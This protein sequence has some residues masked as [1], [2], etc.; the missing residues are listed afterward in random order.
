MFISP[1]SDSTQG[2]VV[3]R[4]MRAE[5]SSA[6]VALMVCHEGCGHRQNGKS[7]PD[8]TILLVLGGVY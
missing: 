5:I 2:P 7:S 4:V 8:Q 1:V 3:V 6:V